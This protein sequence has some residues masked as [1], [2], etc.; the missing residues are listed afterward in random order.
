LVIAGKQ[1]AQK[2]GIQK[3]NPVGLLAG[4]PKW[5]SASEPMIGKNEVPNL[6]LSKWDSR[7]GKL[8]V[9]ILAIGNLGGIFKCRFFRS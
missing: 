9:F 1:E 6:A 2:V 7:Y 4:L 5:R 8:E 3:W